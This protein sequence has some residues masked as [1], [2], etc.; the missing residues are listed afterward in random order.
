MKKGESSEED[1][2]NLLERIKKLQRKLEQKDAT[3]CGR[4]KTLEDKNIEKNLLEAT[5]YGKILD[6]EIQRK[7]ECLAAVNVELQLHFKIRELC[8]KIVQSELDKKN[9]EMKQLEREAES[10]NIEA[11][12]NGRIKEL[13]K[14]LK[15]YRVTREQEKNEETCAENGQMLDTLNPV[16]NRVQKDHREPASER[17]DTLGHLYIMGACERENVEAPIVVEAPLHQET[18]LVPQGLVDS[19][20]TEQLVEEKH[21]EES[22]EETM[23]ELRGRINELEETLAGSG[24]DREQMETTL[25]RQKNEYEEMLAASES[26]RE[27]MDTNLH[28]WNNKLQETLA[29][30]ENDMEKMETTSPDRINKLEEMLAASE[31]DREQMETTFRGLIKKIAGNAGS[32]RE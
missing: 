9:Y 29:A 23:Q 13:E 14:K 25:R 17:Q 4:K 11:V 19:K 30:S 27:Q 18:P 8:E 12:L 21:E 26:D 3:I 24:S 20:K 16:I 31:S 22:V 32:I 7:K 1:K 5:L 6:L 2:P 28:G 10:E 15:E